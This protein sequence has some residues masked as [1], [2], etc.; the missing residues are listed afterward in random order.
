MSKRQ[1]QSPAPSSACSP[2]L[3]LTPEQ[4]LALINQARAG[5]D[6]RDQIILSLQ[7]RV[8]AMAAKYAR[9][10]EQEDFSDL[11]NSANVAL[12]KNYK[13]ALSTPNPYA[14]LIRTARST[15]IDYYRGYGEHT[16]REL[17]AVLSLDRPQDEADTLLID[18]LPVIQQVEVSSVLSNAS[19]ILL[20]QAIAALPEKQRLVIERH[21]G[22]GQAPQSLNALKVGTSSKYHHS[23]ALTTLR[24][25]LAP[26][27]P[28]YV[29]GGA[30]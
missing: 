6:V 14:Y 18:I 13:R 11:V 10:K 25:A 19:S 26:L 17:I 24:T 20:R 21:Y 15:M 23:K 16:Q 2:F 9:P 8:Q 3:R 28:Q 30:Q 4:E 29:A 5:E 12:L 7:R 22:F 1:T 27:L